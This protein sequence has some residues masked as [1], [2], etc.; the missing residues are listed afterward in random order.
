MITLDFETA[1]IVG[2]PSVNP[3]WPV[4]LAIREEDGS[5]RY[6]SWGHPSGNNCEYE[7]AK[8]YLASVWDQ[9]ILYHN[10]RF[11]VSVACDWFDLP[12]PAARLIHDTQY[13]L[14]LTEPH[15]PD[16]SLKPSAERVLGW[17]PEEQDA[18]RDWVMTNVR[19]RKPTE[20]GAY[21][22]RAPASIV[23]P[24]A[25]G[26]VDRTFALYME[27][28][29]RIG[30]LGMAEAYER[31]QQLMP[32]LQQSERH[33]IRVDLE[34]LYADIQIWDKAL[35]KVEIV[36]KMKLGADSSKGMELNVGSGQQL[37]QALIAAGMVSKDWL[38]HGVTATGALSV[39]RPTLAKYLPDQGLL[40]LLSYRGA[41]S[42]ALKTFARPWA[43][44]AEETGGRIHTT[45]N[46]VRH[47]AEKRK[48]GT[49]TG[50]LSSARPNF[51][52]VPNELGAAPSGLPDL[53]YMRQYLLPEEGHVWLKR[54]FSSQEVRI[55]AHFEDGALLKAYNDNPNLDPHAMAQ[56]L[57]YKQ[58]NIQLDRK[59]VKIIG[60]SLIYG[61][62]IAHLSEQLG[63]T[64]EVARDTKEAY[65]N[66][67]PGIRRLQSNL[68]N[69]SDANR[70]M[71]TWGGRVYYAEPAKFINGERREFG[72]KLLNYLIQGSAADQ[73]KE[74]IIGWNSRSS[75]DT[76][77]LATVHDE[78]NISAP[79]DSAPFHMKV[80][81]D[82]MCDNK[83]WDVP[84]LSDGFTGANWGEC[85]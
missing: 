18:V 67:I 82:S 74:A 26:D 70:P 48:G 4:G 33:G 52:N 64:Y 11:D 14:F 51:Q 61:S 65:L 45:W 35:H 53:P 75:A 83:G 57:I 9:P 32:I 81:Q 76:Q 7:D 69:R 78:I 63:C 3:P 37:G 60:F 39:S 47:Q 38:E 15:A 25:I 73:T 46:Q 20:W 22:C 85:K 2:N 29:P 27:L 50:R 13:M 71:R 72:Y 62:G 40:A 36:I 43:R 23:G 59:A 6:M 24:Y 80:L 19:P 17:A 21:I 31:E 56:D 5:T 79:V 54:D 8:W 84:F 44:Q 58:S 12:M 68:R 42:T 41:L 77:F 16:L 10:A 1:G 30:K 66:A 28:A 49:R 55:L 34:K